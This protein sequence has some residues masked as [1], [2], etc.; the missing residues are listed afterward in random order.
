MNSACL[1]GDV[2]AKQK[3][4]LKVHFV[5]FIWPETK[6]STYEQVEESVISFGGPNRRL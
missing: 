3:R 6:W 5:G 2:E 1:S 4:V